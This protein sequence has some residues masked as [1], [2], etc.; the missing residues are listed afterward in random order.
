MESMTGVA[1]GSVT[2]VCRDGQ[3]S[4]T[5]VTAVAQ[6]TG[7]DPLD[8]D[9]LYNVV[10]PDALNRIFDSTGTSSP[11]SVELSF[12]MAG[13]QVVV[14][15]DGEVVVTPGAEADESPTVIGSD[16]E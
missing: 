8:L 3:V 16:E 11:A 12:T 10:D 14:R 7:V 4:E 15:G 2:N 1:A 9:P 6:A 5:V 13:C